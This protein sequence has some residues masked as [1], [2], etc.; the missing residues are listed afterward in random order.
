MPLTA[1]SLVGVHR[2]CLALAAE[3]QASNHIGARAQLLL[4]RSMYLRLRV[5]R[6]RQLA[7]QATI[8][9]RRNDKE[10]SL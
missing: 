1:R 5:G 7:V 4:R 8:A 2:T 9:P 6:C 10:N 3:L